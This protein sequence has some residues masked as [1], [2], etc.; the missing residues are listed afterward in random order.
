[1]FSKNGSEQLKEQGPLDGLLSFFTKLGK[2]KNRDDASLAAAKSRSDDSNAVGSLPHISDVQHDAGLGDALMDLIG[3]D[4][5]AQRLTGSL[6]G[7]GGNLIS[8]LFSTLRRVQQLESWDCG[9]AC[10]LIILRWIDGDDSMDG[11]RGTTSGTMSIEEAQQY[12]SLRAEIETQSIWTADLFLQLGPLLERTSTRYLFCSKTFQVEQ[13]YK[14]VGYYQA[15]FGRDE[16]RVTSIFAK[17]KSDIDDANMRCAPQGISLH[18]VLNA[19]CHPN[20]IALVLID[21]A[22]LCR[23]FSPTSTYE[24]CYVGHYVLLC[25]ISR[26]PEHLIKAQ[27]LEST[28]GKSQRESTNV[29]VV[30]CDPGQD[31]P[32]LSFVTPTRFERSWRAKG[33]DDDIVFIVKPR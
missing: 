18:A 2:S 3:E 29:C 7:P 24:S 32:A 22:I 25:G 21:N 28:E 33:T 1:M 30:L 31:R 6:E 10:L 23:R 12:R 11:H 9:I 13:D 14:D 4:F 8:E 17:L 26:D 16:E 15:A 19:V 20:C 5:N 27:E